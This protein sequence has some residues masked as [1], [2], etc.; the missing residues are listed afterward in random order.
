MKR[1]MLVRL[2]IKMLL[3]DFTNALKLVE[4]EGGKII[5]GGDSFRR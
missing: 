3:K 2:S 4:Q 5:Y 1:I